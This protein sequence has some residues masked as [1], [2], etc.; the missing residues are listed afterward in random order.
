[1]VTASEDNTARLWDADS[2]AEVARP[3]HDGR[4]NSALFSADGTR[5]VTA[6]SDKTA[7][8]WDMTWAAKAR[9]RLLGEG[10]LTEGELRILRPIMVEV[11]PDVVSRW[12]APTS[13]AKE[14]AE[15]EAALDRWRR[16]REMALALA[17]NDWALR[18]AEIKNNLAA[19]GSKADASTSPRRRV[20]WPVQLA[21]AL[22]LLLAIVGVLSATRQI[23]LGRSL[24]VQ[25]ATMIV[26]LLLIRAYS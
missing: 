14:E 22:V 23:D 4:V 8:V 7:R 24:M 10:R 9:A 19:A 17:K 5:V 26:G 25:C 13:D 18:A 12:L 16:H 11:D 2:G 3:A 20:S 15:I 6:S 1:M 21:V